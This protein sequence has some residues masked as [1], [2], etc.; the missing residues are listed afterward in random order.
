LQDCEY[1]WD[2]PVT[3]KLEALN[4]ERCATMRTVLLPSL[5]AFILSFPSS[6]QQRLST[7]T[8]DW[9][10]DTTIKAA[11]RVVGQRYC[12]GDADLF[13]VILDFEIQL[14]NTSKDTLF[15][16]SDMVQ[17]FIRVASDLEAARRGSYMYESGGGM[18]VWSGDHKFPPV[19]EIRVLPGRSVSLR[20]GGWVVARYKSDFSYPGTVPPGRYALQLL[21]QPEKE[22]PRFDHPEL[23]SLI[24]D[25]VAFEIKEDPHPTQCR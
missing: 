24:V 15:L 8:V 23:K 9:T 1:T 20:V 11:A 2:R 17:R 13:T 3:A 22:F 14:F 10:Q 21:L 5:I 12:E 18:S 6:T 7:T 16:R 25:P 4:T 19:R